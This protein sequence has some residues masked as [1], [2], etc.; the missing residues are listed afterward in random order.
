MLIVMHVICKILENTED[1]RHT[2]RN[3]PHDPTALR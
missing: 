2:H 1:H 3:I